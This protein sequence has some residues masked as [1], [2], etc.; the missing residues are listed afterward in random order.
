VIVSPMVSSLSF[1]QL[2]DVRCVIIG[3]VQAG[4]ASTVAVPRGP[5]QSDRVRNVYRAI[6]SNRPFLLGAGICVRIGSA[7][8]SI[9]VRQG[10]AYDAEAGGKG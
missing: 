6:K 2:S 1:S 8:A 3:S 5:A 7:S 9:V 10:D 4:F